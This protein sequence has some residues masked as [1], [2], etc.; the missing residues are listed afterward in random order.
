MVKA[1]ILRRRVGDKRAILDAIGQ[2]A[3][4]HLPVHLTS[5]FTRV[6]S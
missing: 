2:E 4:R 5:P 6:G 3:A 1:H